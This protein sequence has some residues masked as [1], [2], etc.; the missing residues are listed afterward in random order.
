MVP[1]FRTHCHGSSIAS[2]RRGLREL[3]IG[4][5]ALVCLQCCLH[6]SGISEEKIVTVTKED[7]GKTVEIARGDILQIEL[8]GTAT[9]GFWWRF[10]SLDKTYLDLVKQDT[11][12]ISPRQLD[13]API[14]GIWQVRAQQA[15]NTSIEMAYYRS[16]EGIAKAR[17]WFHLI[18]QIR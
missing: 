12:E 8:A 10:T 13:G 1:W 15:G 11:R 7:D 16:W 4:I 5:V 2:A 17:G 9:T 14:M 18:V 3:G 6:P